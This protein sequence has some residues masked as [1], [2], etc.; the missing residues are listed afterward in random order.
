[1]PIGKKFFSIRMVEGRDLHKS[2]MY[3]KNHGEDLPVAITVGVHPAITIASAF[4][5]EWGKSE[6]TIANSL[7]N[8]K[9]ALTKCPISKIAV[10]STSEIVMEGKILQDKTHSEW[11]VEML[12]TYD[13]PRKAPVIEIEKIHYRNNA[14]FHDILSGYG[15]ARLL[16]GMPI[17]SK[18]NGILKKKFKQ[19]K[20]VVLTSGGSNWLHAV[21]QISKTKTT[22]VKK[23]IYETFGA[24]RS[25]KMVT[26]VDDDI[27]PTDASSVEYAMATRFQADKDL[28]IIKNVRGSS[29]DPS[30][31][32]KKL[33]TAKM[34]IDATIPGSKRPEGFRLG[35]LAKINKNLLK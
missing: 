14:I 15:E 34:G 17:E 10:P 33:R 8:N 35:K 28:V 7:L 18:L 9:L 6:A 19:T 13:M 31:D 26:V 3:A 24:H 16:M 25:L 29:L 23:I 27:D 12:R 32:Q 30:S 21:V 1:M 11:M 20:Q 22:N 2:F 5:A 4:Q